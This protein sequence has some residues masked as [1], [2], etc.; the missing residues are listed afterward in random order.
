MKKHNIPGLSLAIIEGGEIVS[1]KYY[2][3]E[4][5]ALSRPVDEK[6]IFEVASLSK[7]VFAYAVLK[8]VENGQ[9][10][11]D[12][13]LSDYF[14]YEDIKDDPRSTTITAGM[15]LNHTTG[16]PN[17]R[18]EGQD[19]KIHFQPGKKFSY[20]GEGFLYLQKVIEQISAQPFEQYMQETV[21][22][23]LDMTQSTYIW[24]KEKAICYNPEGAPVLRQVPMPEA[25]AAFTLH[26]TISDYA[27]FVQAILE[28][29]GLSAKTIIEMLTPCIPVC[30]KDPRCLNECSVKPSS[31][32]FWGLGWGLQKISDGFSFWHWG[33]NKGAKS[34]IAGSQK[35]DA[36]V[37]FT[38]SDNGLN[39]IPEIIYDIKRECHPALKWLG[40]DR[41]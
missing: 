25:N 39:A 40:Y 20:S 27:K 10:D 29:K 33:N 26:T 30:E 37:I 4:D 32:V 31:S 36:I 13:P 38:N 19:L 3:F 41:E 23:P 7:P 5:I 21:F 8:M 11:L 12:K 9:L 24:P 15:V 14:T 35:G 28:N 2:G 22:A 17:W 34:Y 16:F 18:P 1:L 6:T